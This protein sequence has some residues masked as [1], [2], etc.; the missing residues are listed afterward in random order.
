MVRRF[1]IDGVDRAQVIPMVEKLLIGDYIWDRRW[2]FGRCLR[3]RVELSHYWEEAIA[4]LGVMPLA[5]WE[6]RALNKS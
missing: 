2:I 4:G 6:H 5:D 3:L 1:A